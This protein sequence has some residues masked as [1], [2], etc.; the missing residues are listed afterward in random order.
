MI[1]VFIGTEEMQWLAAEVLKHSI[2]KRTKA[3]VEFHELKDMKTGLQLKTYT[4]FSFNRWY[5][6]EAC[7]YEGKAIYLD[8]D[9]VVLGDIAEFH[10]LDMQG[11]GAMAR[12][13]SNRAFYYTSVMLLD[14]PKLTHWKMNEWATL[15][16]T[17][18]LNYDAVMCAAR[19]SIAYPDF[20]PMPDYWNH[21]D[22]W[23]ETTKIL[24]YT[25]VPTQPWKKGGHPL[26]YIFRREL[27]SAITE[28]VLTRADVEKEIAAK[29]VYAELLEDTDKTE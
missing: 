20:M 19:E 23:D 29:H 2:R 15:I 11:K 13:H 22:H 18:F 16:N 26:G 24:H 25:R 14:C 28:G 6:P 10:N 7:H 4:G 5:I 27:K 17:G 21:L 8:A 3:E 1:K 12:A 9:I